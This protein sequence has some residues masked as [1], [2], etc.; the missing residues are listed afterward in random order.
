MNKLFM[1]I[2]LPYNWLESALDLMCPFVHV[3]IVS[4]SEYLTGFKISRRV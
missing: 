3:L 1:G 4:E 2:T